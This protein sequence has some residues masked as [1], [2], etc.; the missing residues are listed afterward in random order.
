MVQLV[1]V[2]ALVAVA[3]AI[4]VAVALWNIAV[5]AIVMVGGTIVSLWSGTKKKRYWFGK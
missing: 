5:G 4:G 2:V 1:K 3:V